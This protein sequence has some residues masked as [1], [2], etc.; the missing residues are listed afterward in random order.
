MVAWVEQTSFNLTKSHRKSLFSVTN[1]FFLGS[2]FAS[3]ILIGNKMYAVG[4]LSNKNA[5]IKLG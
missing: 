4:S 5:V 2:Y 3:Y 1:L